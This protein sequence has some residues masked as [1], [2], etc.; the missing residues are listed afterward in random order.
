MKATDGLEQAI[1]KLKA[2]PPQQRAEVEDFIDFV[3]QRA[4][5][6]T[7]TAIALATSEP[8]LAKLWNNAEDAVYD[9][10]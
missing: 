6:R 7:F 3:S 5:E 2:L 9:E 4:S 10:S 8:A 1:Q